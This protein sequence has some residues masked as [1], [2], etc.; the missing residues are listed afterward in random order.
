MSL[1]SE[2]YSN[3]S[4]IIASTKFN[5]PE[6]YL[7]KLNESLMSLQ[8]IDFNNILKNLP[9]TRKSTTPTAIKY[10]KQ[11]HDS[12]NL[13]LVLGAGISK[14]YGLPTWDFLLQRLLL[15]TIE[16]TPE[17]AVVLS[18]V[19]TKVFNPSPLIAG[20]YLQESLFD[21]KDKNRF[22]KEVRKTLYDSFDKDAESPI[23]DEIVKLCAAPGNSP[24]LDGIITYN[25]DDV[26]ETKIKEKNMDI[27]FQSV[28][29]QA[30]DPDNRALAIYHVHGFL[31]QEGTINELNN[32]TL[33]EYVYHEQYSNIYS[34][35]NIVQINKFRDKTC[36]F[37]GTS[38]SDPNIRRLLD[39]ANSQK[40]GRKFHYII[41]KKSPRVW[42][43]ER[44]KQILDD[45]PQIFNEKVKAKLDF[46]ETVDLLI[47]IQNRFEEKDSESLGVKTVWIEDY[48]KDI[49]SILKK[50]R[51]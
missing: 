25:Y 10:L 16:E 38:L 40:K 11:A 3:L 42:V 1:E 21:T 9:A 44:L 29:G 19:F 30:V 22:E 23:M 39:I 46:D 32:I 14:P 36:L 26:I 47:E 17:K 7:D 27:P 6:N 34:W 49:A 12:E 48:D 37:I 50:I 15:K 33:G 24:N 4:K 45:N 2:Y 18:K 8:K 13:N 35:N 28:Y 51:E 20:R 31:P 41:K 43:Q 5:L